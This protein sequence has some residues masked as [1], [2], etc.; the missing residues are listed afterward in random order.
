MLTATA[1]ASLL[2]VMLMGAFNQASKA[3]VAGENQVE[4]FQTGRAVLDLMSRDLGQVCVGTNYPFSGT[5]STI[6]FY[7]AIGGSSDTSDIYQ[8][9]YT[10]TASPSRTLQ[11]SS[12]PLYGGT[13]SMRTVLV[14]TV[15]GC[16]FAF[17]TNDSNHR[18]TLQ[19]WPNNDSN[20]PVAVEVN[21]G[22]LSS[23]QTNTAGDV[24]SR[25][26]TN[27]INANLRTFH[28]LIFLPG[29]IP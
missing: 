25:A 5:A 13:T 22:L 7:S 10:Y 26:F 19:A 8:I 2:I 16:S 6:S 27:V 17:L 23:R 9:T 1:V 20:A 14:N 12:T 28:E 11:R 29:S 24:T 18:L 4:T 21:L 15:I 3:W